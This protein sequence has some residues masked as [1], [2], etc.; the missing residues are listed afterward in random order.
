MLLPTFFL[1]EPTTMDH[2]LSSLMKAVT[3]R[4]LAVTQLQE[5]YAGSENISTEQLVHDLRDLQASERAVFDAIITMFVS[6]VQA[7]PAPV[8]MPEYS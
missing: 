7:A 3:E 2:D 1:S 6:L 8:A 5:K 4:Q